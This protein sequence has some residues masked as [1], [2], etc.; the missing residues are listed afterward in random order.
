MLVLEPQT[1]TQKFETNDAS[2]LFIWIFRYLTLFQNCRS[3]S[4]ESNM[5]RVTYIRSV[6]SQLKTRTVLNTSFRMMVI[7]KL[8]FLICFTQICKRLPSWSDCISWDDCCLQ[9]PKTRHTPFQQTFYG[10]AIFFRFSNMNF[11]NQIPCGSNCS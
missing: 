6:W 11:W 8:N 2:N 3:N 1:L 4:I 7:L 9:A 10:F 5:N